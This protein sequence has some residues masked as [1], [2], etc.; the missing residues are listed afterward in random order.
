MSYKNDSNVWKLNENRFASFKII[1]GKNPLPNGY[2][3][4]LV[5]I[6]R[7]FSRVDRVEMGNMGDCHAVGE[8]VCELRLHFGAGYRIYFGETNNTIVLLCGGDKASQKTD[9][10]K[11]IASWKSYKRGQQL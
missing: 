10:Q 2:S 3:L 6:A 5:N 8:G 9:I 1:E 7:A 11:A 4:C